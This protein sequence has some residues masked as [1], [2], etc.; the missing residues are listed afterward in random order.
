LVLGYVL[1]GIWG[2]LLGALAGLFLDIWKFNRKISSSYFP[3]EHEQ[4]LSAFYSAVFQV[5]GH[6]TKADGRVS[7][8]EVSLAEEVMRDLGLNLVQRRTAIELFTK[9]KQK[10]FNLKSTVRLFHDKCQNHPDLMKNFFEVQ[11]K[12]ALQDGGMGPEQNNIL[13]QIASILAV[14]QHNLES[15]IEEVKTKE[16]LSPNIP[17]INSNSD[18]YR[19]LGVRRDMDF[20]EIESVYRRLLSENHPDKLISQ[21]VNEGKVQTANEKTRKIREAWT[22]IQQIHLNH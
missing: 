9:G 17:C 4:V 1:Y 10:N 3:T 12:S 20:K 14:K 11:I 21:E 13:G 8:A 5:M 22:K 18:P 16:N 6:I 7:E 15:L 19:I 2:L